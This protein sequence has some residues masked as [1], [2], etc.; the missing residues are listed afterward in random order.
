MHHYGGRI[1]IVQEN[2]RNFGRLPIIKIRRLPENAQTTNLCAI[3]RELSELRVSASYRREWLESTKH[4]TTLIILV[5]HSTRCS[6]VSLVWSLCHYVYRFMRRLVLH[7]RGTCVRL[8]LPHLVC[9][10]R[11]P[12][13]MKYVTVAYIIINHFALTLTDLFWCYLMI[14]AI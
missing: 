7:R 5:L 2:A 4:N 9:P 6:W 1:P 11:C 10:C 3:S 13:M 8:P 14:L 12:V